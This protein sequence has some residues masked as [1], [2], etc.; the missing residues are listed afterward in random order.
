[1]KAFEKGNRRMKK[2]LARA[3]IIPAIVLLNIHVLYAQ[4]DEEINPRLWFTLGTVEGRADL[5]THWERVHPHSILP[6][7]VAPR[8]FNRNTRPV[9]VVSYVYVVKPF[10][11]NHLLV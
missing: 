7:A 8:I 5:F 10:W 4:E 9:D 11:T 2:I 3:I 6:G 1:L